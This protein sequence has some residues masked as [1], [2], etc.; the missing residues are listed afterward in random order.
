MKADNYWQRGE[1]IDYLNESTDVIPH[2]TILNLNSRIGIAGCEIL[3]GAVGSAH[4]TGVFIAEKASDV[5]VLG[6]AVFFDETGQNITVV[7]AGNIPAG[8][9]IEAAAATDTTVKVKLLG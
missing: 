9:A 2:G 7:D 1:S 8:W 6:D 4:V 3:P 5:I